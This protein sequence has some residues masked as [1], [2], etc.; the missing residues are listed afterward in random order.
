MTAG[1]GLRKRRVGGDGLLAP[2]LLGA[3]FG[4]LT[5]VSRE[6]QGASDKLRVLARCDR[7]SS[8]HWALFHNLRKRAE[9][10]AA[11][12]HCNPRLPVLVP[13]WLYQRVQSQMDRCNNPNSSSFGR[14]GARGIKFRFSSVNEAAHWVAANL[15]VPDRA[16]QLDRID[17][18]GH[19]EPGNLRWTT[20]V[21]N[22]NNTRVSGGR[23][24]F[25][26]F[27][28]AFPGVRYADA[29]LARMLRTMT[30][31]E[32]VGRWKKHSHKPKGK[33]GTFSTL[34]PYRG[35]LPTDG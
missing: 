31:E 6:V 29:T 4:S 28:K 14:Y 8:E 13:P 32:I 18:A 10:V 7:C 35:S 12:P 22:Q 5:I 9:S 24:R 30:P 11:C 26:A 20:P 1:R 3:R 27:R 33:Y 23:A 34:G 17:N 15:G 25:I 2:E 21:G 19:Y 16:L